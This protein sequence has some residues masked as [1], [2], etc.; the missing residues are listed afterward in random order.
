[1]T[2]LIGR[3]PFGRRRHRRSPPKSL[4]L[5]AG[6]AA[7]W[8]VAYLDKRR[9]HVARDRAAS[10]VRSGAESVDRQARFVA[11]HAKGVAHEATAPVR[12]EDREYDDVTLARKVES[13]LF[14]PADAPKDSVSVNVRNGVVELRGEVKRPEDVKSL[15]A[16]AAGIDGVKDVHNLL[17]TPGSPPRHSPPSDPAEVRERAEQPRASSRFAGNPATE[18]PEDEPLVE[19]AKS[20]S[21]R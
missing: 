18:E 16:A 21:K 13:E 17:H 1:M 8:L 12:R 4:L 7:G 3:M 2:A 19:R 5:G 11:G 9:R 6:V 15:G 14:R 10:A 20:K